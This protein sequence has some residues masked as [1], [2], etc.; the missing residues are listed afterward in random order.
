MTLSVSPCPVEHLYTEHNSWLRNWLMARL[1]C[2][3]H[4][5][6]LAQDTFVRVLMRRERLKGAELRQPRAFL[7]VIAKGLLIDHFRRRDV[8]KAFVDALSELPEPEALSPE[9]REILL[10]TLQQIDAALDTLAP[11]VRY[12]FLLSQL[13]GLTYAEIAQLM[14][15]SVR[16]VKRYMQQGFSQ[17]LQVLL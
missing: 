6:D 2:H 1:G 13:D 12:A 15:V 14:A 9:E 5:A 11:E 17:C 8:E 10:E 3:Q 7:R 4:A 16:T